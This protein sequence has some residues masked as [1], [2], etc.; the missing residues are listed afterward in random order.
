MS[1]VEHREGIEAG[2]LDMFVDGA[3]AF[4]LTLLAIGGETIP[5][6]AEK[7]L[8]ILAGVPAAAMCF[9]QIAW[10][11]HGHVQWRHLCT[12]STRTGLLLS[13]LLVFFALIFVYPLHMVFGSACYSLS[14]GVLSSDL[15]VQMSSDARTMFVCYGLAYIAMAGTLTL[16]FR[17][18]M[19]L[20]PTG[21]EEHRQAGIRTV[22]W[23]VPTAVGLLSALTA[24]V[25]PTGLLALAGFEYA[26][27]G[28]IGPVIAWYKRR[29][30]TE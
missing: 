1:L 4:T 22:M 20:N 15:A 3:F 30:I 16:L 10:M 25:V 9:A 13:L 24:L 5:N 28:L 29:Y 21:T 23:A 18:A 6:T 11:W 19:R 2:R 12:R 27:L 26:L 7:L 17:H 8:H 14:G